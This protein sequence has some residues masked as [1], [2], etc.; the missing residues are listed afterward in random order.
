[1]PETL[2]WVEPFNQQP[3]DKEANLTFSSKDTL[4]TF[5]YLPALA[6]E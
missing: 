2:G 6:R 3:L 1:M 4:V 5:V